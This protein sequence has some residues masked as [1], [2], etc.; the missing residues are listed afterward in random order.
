MV[1]AMSDP[2]VSHS[3]KGAPLYDGILKYCQR[4]CMPETNEGMAFDAMGICRACR[5]AEEKMHINWEEREKELWEI[6]DWAKANAEGGYDCLVPISGGK[7]STYQLHLITKKY[8]LRPLAVTHSHNWYTDTGWYNLWNSLEK[9]DVDHILYTP[10]RSLV[11]RLAKNSLAKIGDACWH[12]HAGVYSF[13][14]HIAHA[15]GIKLLVYGESLSEFSGRATFKEKVPFV[16][17]MEVEQVS[18]VLPPE[19][20]GDNIASEELYFYN[21]PPVEELNKAGIRR[22]YIGD[23]IFWDAER[24][25]EFVEKEYDWRQD[26]V[27]NSYKRYKSVECRMA[28]VHDYMKFIKRGFGQSA[29]F[30]SMDVRAGLMTRSEGF[31]VANK[32][33]NQRPKALD[34]YLRITGLTEEEVIRILKEKRQGK[35]KDLP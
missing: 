2:L 21:S 4:C 12:C 19:M 8:G 27:E 33:D 20:T 18:R 1:N 11:N 25:T 16:W 7:D 10:K 23:Y 30:A 13:P 3:G 9:L 35:A 17:G 14:L 28:G 15:F 26:H 31:D 29:D 6:L 5:A 24:F 22:I 34:E 32:T